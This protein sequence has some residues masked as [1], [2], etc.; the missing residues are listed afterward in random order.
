LALNLI[1][2]FAVLLAA[3]VAGSLVSRLGYPSILGELFVGMALGPAGLGW[4][5]D[6]PGLHVLA[7]L[8]VYLLMLYIG[9]QV[10]H[11]ELQKASWPGLMA[12]SGGL[13]LPTAAGYLFA[14]YSGATGTEAAFIGLSMGVTALVTKSRILADL[15]LFGTQ[16]G[17]IALA[18]AVISDSVALV[19]FAAII[20]F[21]KTGGVS[22]TRV[23]LDFGKAALYFAV[24][25]LVGLKLFPLV[26]ERLRRAGLQERTANF[27][28]LLLVGLVFA[29]FAQVAG[30]HSILGAFLAGLFVREGVLR[31]R[32][33]HDI[34]GLIHDLSIGFLTPI[35]FVISGFDVSLRVL[36]ERPGYVAAVIALA[37]VT[38]VAGATLF[39]LPTRRNWR[40]GLAAGLAMNGRGA[41]EIILAKIAL[42]AGLIGRETFSVLVFMAFFTTALVPLTLKWAVAWLKRRGELLGEVQ[43]ERAAVV[44]GAGPIGLVLA[45]TLAPAQRVTFIDRNPEHCRAAEK[46]GFRAVNGDALRYE[47]LEHAGALQARRFIAATSNGDINSLV[48]QFAR[49]NGRIPEVFALLPAEAEAAARMLA[50]LGVAALRAGDSLETWERRLSLDAVSVDELQVLDQ[51]T[52]GEA[53]RAWFTGDELPLA[54][55]DT[56][57]DVQPFAPAVELRTGDRVVFLRRALAAGAAADRFDALVAVAGILDLPG[58]VSRDELFTRVAAHFGARLGLPAGEVK[59]GLYKREAE[60]GTVLSEGIAVPHVEIDLPGRLE[61]LIVRAR[62]GVVFDASRGPVRAVFAIATSRDERTEYLRT[63]SA[64]AQILHPPTFMP[65]W[66]ELPGAAA[67]RDYLRS[68]KRQRL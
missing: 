31:K 61:L 66:L 5:Q 27:T 22:F 62:D 53:S 39:Y 18:A 68:A 51:M 67:M 14:R 33:S 49:E 40:E 12:A 26:G 34:A 2:L 13:L 37:S 41:V 35:F 32:L 56:G 9:M 21:A 38:K 30:L 57:G 59:A 54:V 16:L 10:D 4:L 52:A 47:T 60:G 24:T 1:N 3:W 36:I 65:R 48:A 23:A 63:L 17:A 7:E 20:G 58:R 29:E 25:A 8:G 6:D 28:L 44:F 11:R 55:A 19:G 15:K 64:I 46:A 50:E 45:K 43:T 42:E